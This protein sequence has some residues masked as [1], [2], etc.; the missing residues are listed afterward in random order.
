MAYSLRQA[1]RIV[2][3][4]PATVAA[5]ARAGVIAVSPAGAARQ[6][7]LLFTFA[8]LATLRAVATLPA[9]AVRRSLRAGRSAL[10]HASTGRRLRALGARL[11]VV[12][13]DGRL[14]DAETGQWLLGFDE[15]SAPVARVVVSAA[16][17]QSAPS[18]PVIDPFERALLLEATDPD[19]AAAGYRALL[20]DEPQREDAYLNLGVLLH[21]AG[22][23]REALA[24]YSEGLAHL[25]EAA[26]LHFNHGVALQ[27]LGA[28][29]QARESYAA[30]LQ[31]DPLFAD[32]HH[33]L[34]LCCIETGDAQAAA[35]HANQAR[36]LRSQS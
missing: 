15:E 5:L 34:A 21:D 20:H 27:A 14:W 31:I 30:T 29:G 35:R 12:E 16:W 26:M 33:N 32:A 11:V 17:N 8:D 23:L 13:P 25:P 24:V 2:G 10:L 28:H 18:A 4:A 19:A 9:T 6:G 7:D 36:R 22:R 3:L 1:S